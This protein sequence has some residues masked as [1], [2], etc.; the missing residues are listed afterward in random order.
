M[1]GKFCVP[2]E[3]SCQQAGVAN[4]FS[5]L[6]GGHCVAE[7]RDSKAASGCKPAL[8][9]VELQYRN[10]IYRI[11]QHQHQHQTRR[12]LGLQLALRYATCVHIVI[13]AFFGLG[14]G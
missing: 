10:C 14:Q 1:V 4:A 7:A 9:P 13:S 2:S 8:R 6:F 12:Q 11:L 3:Q 5:C